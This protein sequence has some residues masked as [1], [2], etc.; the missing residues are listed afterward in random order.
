MRERITQA[1]Q[2]RLV[3]GGK[4]T[5]F[6][7]LVP[8]VVEEA[9][10]SLKSRH[11]L[12]LA[13][14]FGGA[15][16]AVA[17]LLLGTARPEFDGDWARQTVAD[18][19]A[20]RALYDQHGGDFVTLEQMGLDIQTSRAQGLAAALNNGLDEAENRELMLATDPTQIAR[21]VL[22]GLGRLTH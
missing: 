18:Y 20:S 3:L 17:D 5:G 13:G 11:P 1:S 7:G 10:L 12:F 15:A 19:D 14:G 9:W 2:A 16:R 6:A 4:L 8:G 22:T 21:L